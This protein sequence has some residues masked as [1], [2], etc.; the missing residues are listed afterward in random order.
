MG[1]SWGDLGASWERLGASGGGLGASWVGLLGHVGIKWF[2]I[3]FGIDFG[4][5]WRPKWTPRG[6]QNGAQNRSKLITKIM[7]KYEGFQVPL[8]SVLGPSWAVLESILG[9]KFIK[10]HWFYKGS[11]KIVFLSK[12]RLGS[13][14]WTDLGSILIP[15]GL[16]KGSQM[17]AKMDQKWHRKTIKK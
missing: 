10:F 2:L 17:G 12:I 6:A 14:S 13:A 1:A 4:S 15:K 16:P 5:I 8:G 7:I 11:V 3:D 9:S